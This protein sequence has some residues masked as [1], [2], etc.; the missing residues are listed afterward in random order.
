LS[1]RDW[2]RSR[3]RAAVARNRKSEIGRADR[4]RPVLEIESR[5]EDVLAVSVSV[6]VPFVM[7]TVSPALALAE[8]VP[9]R[10]QRRLM[11]W[12]PPHWS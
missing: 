3:P 2:L 8:N 4:C 10:S 7:V 1:K 12:R 11:P 9:S 6:R 5:I